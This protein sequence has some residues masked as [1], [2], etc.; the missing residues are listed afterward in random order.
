MANPTNIRKGKVIVYQG[1]PHAVVEMMHRT[2][3]RQAGFVQTT[4]RNLETGSS[5]NV[6]F[7]STDS[8]EFLHTENRKLEYSYKDR[9]GYHFMDPETYE[10]ILIG[11]E[12]GK[13][14]KDFLIE[15]EKY[16]LLYVDD[17]PLS[18]QLP[19]SVSMKVIEAPE[20]I[21]GDTVNNVQKPVTLETG[22]VVSVPLFIKAGETIRINTD[23][24]SYAGRA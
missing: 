12:M 1:N 8:V 6:K 18:I 10:D 11:T 9:D 5:T 16:D 22:L 20:A 13:E 4:L 3:G 2:Q 19:P 14:A 7:R 15:N 23:D 24:V 21:K 17:R